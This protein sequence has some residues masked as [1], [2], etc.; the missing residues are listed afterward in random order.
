M[1]NKFSP[2]RLATRLRD[3][4]AFGCV[5]GGTYPRWPPEEYYRKNPQV[6]KAELVFDPCGE[7]QSLLDEL[8]RRSEAHG[9]TVP[10]LATDVLF[11]NEM[12]RVAE[13]WK[14]IEEELEWTETAAVKHMQA[15][16]VALKYKHSYQMAE[17]KN[18]EASVKKLVTPALLKRVEKCASDPNKL[19]RLL[20]GLIERARRE[21]AAAGGRKKNA[22]NELARRS[23]I[24]RA[25][26]CWDENPNLTKEQV[27]TK[28]LSNLLVSMS[29]FA[30]PKFNG[31]PNEPFAIKVEQLADWIRVAIPESRKRGGRPRKYRE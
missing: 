17:I 15:W 26:E 31:F 7:N 20:E 4:R 21:T 19:T 28:I 24:E 14:P 8:M 11:A 18:D 1:R 12:Q 13:D 23:A 30:D 5:R 25:Q 22:V 27:A 6:Y 29:V 16:E 2:K 10:F 3:P 9:A